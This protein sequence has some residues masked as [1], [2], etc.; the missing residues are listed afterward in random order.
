MTNVP[1]TL[2]DL[3]LATHKTPFFHSSTFVELDD[4]RILHAAGSRFTTS[5]DGGI[6]WSDISERHDV[7]GHQVGGGG[8]SLVKLDGK[9]IGLAAMAPMDDDDPWTRCVQFWRSPDG[10][11]TW[12]APVRVSP[13]NI[14]THM[15][16]DVALR[17]SSGRIILPVY[18][19]IGQ[20]TPPND[21]ESPVSGKL[22]HNQWV[23][24]AGHF[25]DP[26]YSMVYVLYS[27]DDGRTW[28]RNSDGE[29]N[30]I[31]D[32]NATYSYVNEPTV[33]EVQP[34]ILLMMMRTGVG[35]IYQAWSHDNGE[36]WTRPYPTSLAS[37][38]APCQIRTLPTG[39]LLAVWNQ[40]NEA[41][42]K[43]GFN[44]TRLSS[45]S[46]A[47]AGASGSSSRTSSPSTRRPASSPAR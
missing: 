10:G 22:V 14:K 5:D 27:D 36:T 15:Y 34:G 19:S 9:G 11:E 40:E 44:R 42:V 12:E 21:M 47:T 45:A 43:M 3:V 31:F 18:T 13:V 38:T 23:S 20:R 26:G 6:T 17:T 2:P 4:G 7:N 39:H 25:F 35:R 24:T 8:S 32:W 37:S 1:M 33:T 29:L 28:Q 46:A 16:Q 41:E 30:I